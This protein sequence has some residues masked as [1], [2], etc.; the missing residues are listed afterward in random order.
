[1][2]KFTTDKIKNFL[3]LQTISVAVILIGIFGR[4]IQLVFFFNIRVDGSY[5]HMAMQNFVHGHGITTAKVLPSDLSMVVYEPLINWPPGYSILLAP[6]YII[7]GHNYIAAGLTLDIICAAILILVSRSVLKLLDVPLYLINLYTLLTSFFVYSFYFIASTD[8]IAIALFVSAIYFTISVLKNDQ[9]DI[10]KIIFLS[11]CLLICGWIKYLFIPVVFIIPAFLLIKGIRDKQRRIKK[12]GFASLIILLI[13]IAGLLL[14]QN[15]VG[16]SAGYISQPQRGFFPEHILDSYPFI[17]ASIIKPDTIEL[18]GINPTLIYQFIHV[19]FVLFLLFFVSRMLLKDR[20]NNLSAQKS[21]F[22]ISFFISTAIT[23]LLILLS[24]RVAKEEILPG[25][26]WTYVEESRYY[27]LIFVLIHLS[28]FVFYRN[29]TPY[30]RSLFFILMLLLSVET[31]RGIFFDARRL[32]LFTKEEYSWQYE[33]RFQKYAHKI[34]QDEQQK[35]PVKVVVTGSVYFMNHRISLYSHV[36][37]LYP[38]H[39]INTQASL[40]TKEKV[41]LLVV[42]RKKN[43]SEFNFF[44]SSNSNKLAGQFDDFYFYTLYVQPN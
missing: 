31:C 30:V 34:I 12:G 7:S 1:M 8:A 41:L 14:Y 20:F 6:F 43:L 16:G 32:Y 5:Q 17:P 38:A 27:G 19:F 33:N 26:L 15:S 23:L 11:I 9:H 21:F 22:Y 25:W 10:R 4:I 42:L 13:G 18:T 2:P 29:N 28:L 3:S 37:I 44:L 39:K 35:H 40:Q 24:L 36:P